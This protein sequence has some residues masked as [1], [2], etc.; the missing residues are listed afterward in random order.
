ML[1][2]SFIEMCSMFYDIIYEYMNVVCINIFL[3]FIIYYLDFKI[4]GKA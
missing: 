2:F 3:N 1:S 4:Q